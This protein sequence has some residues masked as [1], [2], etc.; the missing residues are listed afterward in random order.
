MLSNLEK[1]QIILASKSPRR[2]E[3]LNALGV[4]FFIKTQEELEEIYPDTLQGTEIVEF[5][6][7]QKSNF[8]EIKNNEL[9]I[10]ADTIVCVE[11]KVLG[12]P[13]N[14]IEAKKMLSLLSGKTHQVFTG[15]CIRTREKESVFS[16]ASSVTFANLTEEEID[17]YI[18]HFRPLDKAGAYGIQEWIGFIGIQSISGSYWNVMGLPLQRLY[19]E[20][21]KF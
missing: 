8:F 19:Q 11:N 1:Y 5:L 9:I 21:K 15:V 4:N 17:F 2:K 18:K 3:L 14:E 6:A 20:L 7:K 10:S 16:V 12:K 13:T